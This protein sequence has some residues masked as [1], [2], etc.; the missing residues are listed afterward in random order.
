MKQ[1]EPSLFY[2]DIKWITTPS[3]LTFG[4]FVAVL[5]YFYLNTRFSTKLEF[6]SSKPHWYWP[7]LW[8]WVRLIYTT[9]LGWWKMTC[10][11]LV[12]H[13]STFKHVSH[14]KLSKMPTYKY[15]LPKCYGAMTDVL[16]T[17]QHEGRHCI[18]YINPNSLPVTVQYYPILTILVRIVNSSAQWWQRLES[19]TTL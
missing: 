2:R 4:T 9:N 13:A 6:M 18:T 8:H 17:M 12:L 10:I 5:P 3:P 11:D 15:H 19:H 1:K 14:W 16:K 7:S